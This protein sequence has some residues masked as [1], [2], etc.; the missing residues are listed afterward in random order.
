MSNPSGADDP[1]T[2]KGVKTLAIRL[3]PD[4]HTQLTLIAGLRGSTITDE[5]KLALGAHIITAKYAADLANR[6]DEALAEIERDAAARREAIATLFGDTA[7][8]PSG[9]EPPAP[10]T[11]RGRGRK[12]TTEGKNEP[13]SPG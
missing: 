5:I 12:A 2:V 13:G 6:A 4:V 11:P 3:D 9:D 7:P 10:A 1:T 8:A